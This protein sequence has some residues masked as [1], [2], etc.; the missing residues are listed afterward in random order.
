MKSL[1]YLDL[2][3]SKFLEAEKEI[4]IDQFFRHVREHYRLARCQRVKRI[5]KLDPKN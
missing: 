4:E 3:S 1:K 5:L 2:E